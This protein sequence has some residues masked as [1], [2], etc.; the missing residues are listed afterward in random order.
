MM[1]KKIVVVEDNTDVRENLAEI[2]ALDGY[3]VATAENGKIGVK[4][5]E[6]TKPDLVICDIMMPELDGYGVLHILNK[7]PELANI[8]F[9]FLTAKAEKA[10]F[11]KGMNLGADDYLT[12]PFQADEL[13]S[14]VETRIKLR[15]IVDKQY[16]HNLE[17]LSNFFSDAKAQLALEDLA[18]DRE[19]K[20]FQKKEYIFRMGKRPY[21]LF[22]LLSGKVKLLEENIDGKELIT[23][24]V[25]PNEFIGYTALIQDEPYHLNAVA[26]EDCEICIIPKN[27]FLNLIYKDA[28][29]SQ[30]FIKM[31]SNQLKEKEHKLLNMAYNSVR[32]RVAD[33]L[34]EL[35]DKQQEDDNKNDIKITVLRE[36]LA[37]MVGTA[38]ESAIRAL[39]D[40][41]E[42]GFI[43][44]ETGFIEIVDYEG[45][46]ELN[47]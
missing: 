39:C 20:T 24:I 8:P 15:E 11:R 40:I 42:T 23:Q 5:I 37:A 30:K 13:L 34:V 16:A 14:T 7:K 19:I 22:Y 43:K 27:D 47:W 38:K 26:L 45:L 12:K 2:L 44:I 35:V 41:K 28:N 36:D 6:E 4:V 1:A 17:G 29:V 25:K 21:H 46:R 9:L 32:K 18:A 33:S 10:D 31:L 3:D